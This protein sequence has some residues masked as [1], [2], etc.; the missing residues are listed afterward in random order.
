MYVRNNYSFLTFT[1]ASYYMLPLSSNTPGSQEGVLFFTDIQQQGR[2]NGSLAQDKWD[3]F[4]EFLTSVNEAERISYLSQLQVMN[5]LNQVKKGMTPLMLAL[6][7][8]LENVSV[9]LISNGVIELDLCN[10]KGESAFHMACSRGHLEVVKKMIEQGVNVTLK[11]HLG[12]SAFFLAAWH[13]QPLVLEY[14]CQ[15][16]RLDINQ[17]EGA[18]GLTALHV[19]VLRKHFE[20][21][22]KLLDLGAD[23]T[24]L[25]RMGASPFYIAANT[26]DVKI[27]KCLKTRQIDI[28]QR[29]HCDPALYTAAYLGH[30]EAVKKLLKWK[31]DPTLTS[32]TGCSPFCAATQGNHVRIMKLLL[33]TGQV[34]IDRKEGPQEHTALHIATIA[35]NLEAIQKLLKWGAN[36]TLY[37]VDNITPLS[38]SLLVMFHN[39]FEHRLQIPMSFLSHQMQQIDLLK[40]R[41]SIDRD[42]LL[43][44]LER[45][46]DLCRDIKNG[47]DPNWLAIVYG[48]N[49]LL[50]SY[51]TSF[52]MLFDFFKKKEYQKWEQALLV[53]TD[54]SVAIN[55]NDLQELNKL[56]QILSLQ[57]TLLSYSSDEIAFSQ[58]ELNAKVESIQRKCAAYTYEQAQKFKTLEGL[59]QKS[60]NL[61]I[62][63]F[64][65]EINVGTGSTVDGIQQDP[66]L[67]FDNYLGLTAEELSEKLAVSGLLEGKDFRLVG[68]DLTLKH[69]SSL[70]L[71]EH[72]ST[73]IIKDHVKEK[74]EMLQ[75]IDAQH[76]ASLIRKLEQLQENQLTHVQEETMLNQD[77]KAL[78]TTLFNLN[79]KLVIKLL[80]F[81]LR[82]ENQNHLSVLQDEWEKHYGEEPF[83]LST[84][85]AGNHSPNWTVRDFYHSIHFAS[86]NE[87]I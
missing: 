50:Q 25:S 17:K 14:L 36:P 22:E 67:D 51:R 74:R 82:E 7:K 44:I 30:L 70:F 87:K 9:N 66:L 12:L 73:T 76:F 1:E 55:L 23:P 40:G 59:K 29:T 39:N 54:A 68:I 81:L 35:G 8:D 43:R 41:F 49:K 19:A 86:E 34:D 60:D 69:L 28:N 85:M 48:S 16:C 78:A 4:I 45:Q 18:Q 2:L 47:C 31:A 10:E 32:Q 37:N 21:V 46:I 57:Q 38:L 33:H 65:S 71:S 13:N 11:N 53:K 79:R 61:D 24:T 56:Q 15:F 58:D 62:F 27:L 63:C 75:Q 26:N 72:C 83:V 6:T 52:K 64:L 3:D 77:K 42:F 80:K 5:C 20:T 84:L